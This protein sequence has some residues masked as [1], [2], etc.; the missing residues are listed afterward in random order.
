M[1]SLEVTPRWRANVGVAHQA[2]V[3]MHHGL[4]LGRR[5]G[6]GDHDEVIRGYYL[7]F[8]RRRQRHNRF[9]A[10][11]RR[12]PRAVAVRPDVYPSQVGR[13][14]R[15]DHRPS[16]GEVRQ[17]IPHALDEVAAGDRLAHEHNLHIGV[18]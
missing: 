15:S 13:L 8:G 5:T 14:G 7:V 2:A 9:G 17:R 10:R 4:R 6:C 3:R 11:P 18:S 16:V 1:R 12:R